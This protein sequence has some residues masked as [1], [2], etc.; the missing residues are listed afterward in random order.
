MWRVRRLPEV[1]RAFSVIWNTD[2]LT[3]S[4][5]VC[6]TVCVQGLVALTDCTSATGGLCVIPGSHSSHEAICKQS[7]VANALKTDFVPIEEDNDVLKLPKNF[8]KCQAGD[9]CVWDSRLVHCNTPANLDEVASALATKK[10]APTPPRATPPEL[11]RMVA[12]CC[13]TPRS[14][15]SRETLR[16]RQLAYETGLSTSHWPHCN[17]RV[18]H[19]DF[20]GTPGLRINDAPESEIMRNLIGYD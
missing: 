3:T 6:N 7:K 8:V 19:L 20:D 17:I 13:M 4:L 2:E 11:L 16:M 14:F 12:Y 5:D 1:K 10:A 18:P 9:L 15:A